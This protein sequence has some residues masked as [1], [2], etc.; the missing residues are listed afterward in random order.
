MV[1]RDRVDDRRKAVIPMCKMDLDH[2][3]RDVGGKK[4]CMKCGAVFD[5][6]MWRWVLPVKT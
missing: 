1:L 6:R 2:I 5:R 4:V 3:V